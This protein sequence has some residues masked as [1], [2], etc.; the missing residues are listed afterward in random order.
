MFSGD[1]APITALEDFARGA[2]LLIH[3]AMLE[4]ALPAQLE[5]VGNSS[6]Y[7]MARWLQSHTFAHDAARTQFGPY[8]NWFNVG[9]VNLSDRGTSFQDNPSLCRLPNV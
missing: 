5:R 6:V 1:T 4:S 3:E 8:H 7:L 9:V 2:D